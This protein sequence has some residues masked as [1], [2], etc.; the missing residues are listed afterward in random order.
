M[1]VDAFAG[2]F[3]MLCMLCGD[4]SASGS[5]SCSASVKK[6]PGSATTK[7]AT[8]E[9]TKETKDSR[10]SDLSSARVPAG[11]EIRAS[12]VAPGVRME[13]LEVT[14]VENELRVRGETRRGATTFSVD[15][16]IFLPSD[17]D[18][19]TATAT[20]ADGILTIT[21][22]PKAKEVTRLRVQPIPSAP[23]TTSTAAEQDHA[24]TTEERN[25]VEPDVK[26]TPKPA[27][28]SD[29][30]DEWETLQQLQLQAKEKKAGERP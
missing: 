27:A 9:A 5:S 20:H 29:D 25:E 16:R 17:A 21:M 23:S 6:A 15:K 24:G 13:D 8:K 12:I 11:E 2:M 19:E 3:C 26:I 4:C 18:F 14:I 30:D 28:A 7:E 22:S 10:R 1:I